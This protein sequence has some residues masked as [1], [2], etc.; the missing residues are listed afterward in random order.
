MLVVKLKLLSEPIPPVLKLL[1]QI[2]SPIEKASIGAEPPEKG[3]LQ[4]VPGL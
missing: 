2:S 1:S 4:S 3:I